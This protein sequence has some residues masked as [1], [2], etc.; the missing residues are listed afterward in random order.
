M[1]S[2]F[3]KKLERKDNW[4]VIKSDDVILDLNEIK[5][6]HPALMFHLAKDAPEL[7]AIVRESYD[8]YPRE[9]LFTHYRK[10]PDVSRQASPTT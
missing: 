9:F 10:Y 4:A 2:N 5:K 7:A 8:L 6:K 3:S 1:T